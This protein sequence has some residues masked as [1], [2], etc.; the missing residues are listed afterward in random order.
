[1]HFLSVSYGFPF[2]FAS[3]PFGSYKGLKNPAPS[4]CACFTASP[5]TH[6]FMFQRMSQAY[7]SCLSPRLDVVSLKRSKG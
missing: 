4:H 2:G 6:L 1:M 7:L 5:Y 3:V